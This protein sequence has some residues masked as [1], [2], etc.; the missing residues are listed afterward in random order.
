MEE[1]TKNWMDIENDG[2]LLY[3]ILFICYSF[4][5]KIENILLLIF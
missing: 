1:I 5:Y 4:N 2:N 3:V